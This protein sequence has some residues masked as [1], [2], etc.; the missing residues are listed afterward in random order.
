ML[1]THTEKT[2]VGWQGCR[3]SPPLRTPALSVKCMHVTCSIG[4]GGACRVTACVC[5][6]SCS[7]DTYWF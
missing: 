3:L 7:G 4:E 2:E 6:W 5:I 1:V